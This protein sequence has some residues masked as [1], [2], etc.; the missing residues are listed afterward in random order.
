MTLSVLIPTFN[1]NARALVRDMVQRANREGIAAE[2]IVGDDAS[3]AQTEWLREVERWEGVRV[4]RSSRNLG[5]AAN[6][7]R[8]ADAAEGEWLLFVD[9]DAAVPD[10]YSLKTL[11]TAGRQAPVVCGGLCHP[12]TNPCP[13][14]TLRYAYERAADQHR[15]AEERRQHPYDQLTFFHLMMKRSVFQR[16]RLDERCTEYGYEDALFGVE[17]KRAAIPICHVDCPLLHM[18]LES[19]QVFLEKSE[20]ALR[21]LHSLQGRMEGHSRVENTANRL[22]RYQLAGIVAALYRLTYNLLRRNLLGQHPNLKL[23]AFYKLGYFL[24]IGR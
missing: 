4:L 5:R 3:T 21:T 20:T 2:V 11:L 24:N 16:L 6:R 1:Y 14:A 8:M 23:F 18:G 9:C 7:N 13:E 15:G 10:D 17:L 22:R 12:P 19:N